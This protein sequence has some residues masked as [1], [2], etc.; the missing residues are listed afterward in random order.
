M[1]SKHFAVREQ[2]L[3]TP[4]GVANPTRFL[5]WDSQPSSFKHYPH[6]CYRLPIATIPALY[7]LKSLRSITDI[8]SIS[9]KSYYRLNT[10]SAG[11][12]H[13]IEIYLQ[14]RNV[15]G[16]LN[17]VYHWDVLH[18]EL[19][20]IEEIASGGCEPYLGMEQRFSGCLLFF[21][22]VPFR[23][24]WKYGLRGWRYLYL[25]LGHQLGVLHGVY[26]NERIKPTKLSD[27]DKQ[28]LCRI[29]GLGEDEII[30]GI[31]ALGE[32]SDR[33]VKAL[34]EPLMI[35]SPCDYVKRDSV[36]T[37]ALTKDECY[38]N[39]FP[40][41]GSN[42]SESINHT[43]RSARY[44]NP[45]IY[46]DNWLKEL[47]AILPPPSLE[48]IHIV[49]RA[50]SMQLGVYKEGKCIEEGNFIAEIVHLLLDQHFLANASMV[51]LIFSDRFDAST[52]IE[53][54]IIAQEYYTLAEKMTIGCS[55]IGAFYDEYAK[56]W[57]D[58]SL[59]YAVAIGGK[60]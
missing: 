25:D 35:V 58:K 21:S 19:V 29:L 52:H 7:W 10:P 31:Y 56:R 13:P 59:L 30:G 54:G 3:L 40:D 48:I 50:H 12:L 46:D 9:K 41:Y 18:E 36:L 53:A 6:F 42:W 43:R 44:F 26:H 20:L 8:Q 2:T 17:G 60:I 23:S 37:E 33:S 38:Q 39:F 15:Q 24:F 32:M 55:G 5:D 51:S 4:Q 1:F 28:S 57:S 47:F 27:I 45:L 11:N 14:I 16:V 49:F 34:N 22:L